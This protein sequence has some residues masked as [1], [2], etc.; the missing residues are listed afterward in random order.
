MKLFKKILKPGDKSNPL[1]F[2]STYT[3]A[4]PYKQQKKRYQNIRPVA[5]FSIFNSFQKNLSLHNLMRKA[6]RLRL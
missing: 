6:T 3:Y 2:H 4:I 5:L 1:L